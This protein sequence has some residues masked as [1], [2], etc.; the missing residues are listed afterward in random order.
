MKYI[1]KCFTAVLVSVA[2]LTSIAG[3]S[4]KKA[5]K[6][7]NIKETTYSYYEELKD[8]LDGSTNSL[9]MMDKIGKYLEKNKFSIEKI[10]GGNILINDDA[11]VTVEKES[12]GKDKDICLLVSADAQ[13]VRK[14]S[15]SIATV[16]SAIVNRNKDMKFSVIISPKADDKSYGPA[17][18]SESVLKNKNIIYLKASDDEN[19]YMG[20]ASSDE[21]KMSRGISRIYPKGDIAYEIEISGLPAI[22]SGDRKN[23]HTNSITYLTGILMKAKSADINLEIANF[24]NSG[25]VNEYPTGGKVTVVIEKSSESKF[26]DRLTNSE[27]DFAEK[28]REKNSDAKLTFKKVDMPERV[29]DYNDTTGLLSLIYT[30]EDGVVKTTKDDYEGDI[31]GLA[32]ISKISTD[33]D[34]MSVSVLARAMDDATLQ[35]MMEN[36]IMTAGI[37]EFSTEKISRFSRWDFSE[38]NEKYW[39]NQKT[40]GTILGSKIQPQKDLKENQIGQLPSDIVSGKIVDIEFKFDD[41]SDVIMN[42]ISFLEN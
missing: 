8:E 33:D 9:A 36:Y 23:K 12:Q 1:C 37:L 22:D 30:L 25:N 29:L 28:N 6:I 18:L 34:K 38:E 14:T 20:S 7:N 10:D 5:E 24:K 17:K 35:E 27:K 31:L 41:Y 2:L 19:V 42:L 3:C 21:L 40:V 16:L 39:Q 15:Q 13:N 11:H 32:T 4:S 26:V